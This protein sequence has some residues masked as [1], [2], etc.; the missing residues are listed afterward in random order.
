VRGVQLRN[1]YI[2][3]STSGGEEHAVA[4]GDTPNFPVL[5]KLLEISPAGLGLA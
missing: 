2:T 4:V 5:L 3:V 1:G